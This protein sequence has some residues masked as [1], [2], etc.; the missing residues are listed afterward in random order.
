MNK[1]QEV[2]FRIALENLK[3]AK[4]RLNIIS[5]AALGLNKDKDGNSVENK[6]T[7][8]VKESEQMSNELR[9]AIRLFQIVADECLLN[10]T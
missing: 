4:Q 1:S 6:Y 9:D 10:G 5:G 3:N 2:V 8:W 7:G